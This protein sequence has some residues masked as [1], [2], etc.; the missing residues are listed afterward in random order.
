M[1]VLEDSRELDVSN[2]GC[3]W[4]AKQGRSDKEAFVCADEGDVFDGSFRE[5]T[6]S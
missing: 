5:T 6:R 3:T 1:T 4:H 2:L